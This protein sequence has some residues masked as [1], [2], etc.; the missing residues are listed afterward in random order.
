MSD[1]SSKE[2]KDRIKQIK[3]DSTSKDDSN[4]VHY[5]YSPKG[6]RSE[7]QIVKRKRRTIQARN[8]EHQPRPPDNYRALLYN[9][10][11]LIGLIK[12]LKLA[13]MVKR[14]CFEILFISET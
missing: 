2:A 5:N 9:A 8:E 3:E 7:L 11:S 12:N 1:G 14:E 13:D 10:R 4:A 6:T